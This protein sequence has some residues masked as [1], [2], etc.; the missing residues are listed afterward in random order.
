[1]PGDISVT[2]YFGKDTKIREHFKRTHTVTKEILNNI[3]T[4]NSSLE[5]FRVYQDLLQEHGLLGCGL[6]STDPATTN[7]GHTLPVI[8]L[9]GCKSISDEQ[10]K[11]I[12]NARRF[13]NGITSWTFDENIQFTV[14]PQLMS[15]IEPELPQISYH[16]IACKKENDIF[17]CDD[18][19]MLLSKFNLL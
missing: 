17:I 19:N 10:R 3:E 12:S 11:E 8:N 7:I 1:M 14:E 4:C 18:I 13:I 9:E 5:L 15:R 16:Y 6:S 2:L